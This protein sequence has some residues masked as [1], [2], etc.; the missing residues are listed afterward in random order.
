MVSLYAGELVPEPDLWQAT[1]S[2]RF[3][4]GMLQQQFRN[5][6][7]KRRWQNVAQVAPD[8]PD[9]VSDV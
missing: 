6:L 4:G 9:E 7:G 5:A 3:K 2:F 8:A 1:V